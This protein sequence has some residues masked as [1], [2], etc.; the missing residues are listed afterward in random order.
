MAA[1]TNKFH[2]WLKP[3]TDIIGNES[4]ALKVLGFIEEKEEQ[5]KERRKAIQKEGIRLAREKGV[6][7]GR[8]RKVLPSNYERIYKDF[9]DRKITAEQAADY[10]GIGLSTFYRK[11]KAYEKELAQ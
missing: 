6:N 4:V 1:T 9:R 5:E 2:S 3:L 11:V 10:C 7:L 8:P